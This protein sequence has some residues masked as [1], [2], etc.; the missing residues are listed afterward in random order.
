M[1]EEGGEETRTV[2]LLDTTR[3]NLAEEV[4]EMEVDGARDNEE[5]QNR[6]RAVARGKG[7]GR[8]RGGRY[9]DN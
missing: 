5:D 7:R 3:D 4:V 8:G 1:E 6:E 9:R 2:R